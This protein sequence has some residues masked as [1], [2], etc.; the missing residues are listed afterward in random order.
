ML[1]D[2]CSCGRPFPVLRQI[3]GRQDDCVIAPDGRR[4]GRMDPIFKSV[5]SILETRI[6][7]DQADH[8]RVEI[9]SRGELPLRERQ[10]LLRE[11]EA[12]VGISMRVD[13]VRVSVIAR[14]PSGKRRAVVNL[15]PAHDANIVSARSDR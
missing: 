11:I 5:S 12:R 13:L 10:A 7:Q 8:L 2:G 6:V 1:G 4:I 9:V 3:I 15:V 14:S